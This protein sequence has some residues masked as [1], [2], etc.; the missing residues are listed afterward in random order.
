MFLEDVFGDLQLNQENRISSR[1][2]RVD[3]ICYFSLTLNNKEYNERFQILIKTSGTILDFYKDSVN[4]FET[5]KAN[6][7]IVLFKTTRKLGIQQFEFKI[8]PKSRR[9]IYDTTEQ[10][11]TNY[12]VLTKN[13]EDGFLGKHKIEFVVGILTI[14]S[15]L[16]SIPL[17]VKQLKQK[18]K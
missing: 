1:L 17:G 5:L 13:K 2:N 9:K 7:S 3:S 12:K 10:I 14:I 4:C 16:I 11:K 8:K 6:D 15:L 18:S